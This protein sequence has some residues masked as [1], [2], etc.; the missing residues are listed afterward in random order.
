M[1]YLLIFPP[2]Q[3]YSI[4]K[5]SSL[6]VPTVPPLGLL[7]LARA[8]ENIKNEVEIIDFNSE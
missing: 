4:S 5:T 1:K 6:S 8:L 3:Y 2:T 7:Y